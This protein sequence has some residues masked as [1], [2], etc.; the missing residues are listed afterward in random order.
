[1]SSPRDLLEKAHKGKSKGEKTMSRM[2]Y[3]FGTLVLVLAVGAT[4]VGCS[5]VPSNKTAHDAVWT[6]ISTNQWQYPYIDVV[7]MK[8]TQ[9][10]KPTVLKYTYYPV[11]VVL[12]KKSG[13]TLQNLYTVEEVFSVWK[14]DFGEWQAAPG[15]W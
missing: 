3:L 4:A 9:I 10:G 13:Q 5:S 15:S 8:V 7:G 2:L 1:M 6:Y 14:D 11:K 12:T